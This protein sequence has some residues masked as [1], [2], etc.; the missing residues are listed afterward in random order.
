[1]Q[2]EQLANEELAQML[3]EVEQLSEDQA[4]AILVGQ[5]PFQP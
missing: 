2:S 4:H 3:A 1:V 5:Q